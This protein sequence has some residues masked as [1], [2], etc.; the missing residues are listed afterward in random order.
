[1][2]NDFDMFLAPI[3]MLI[4]AGLGIAMVISLARSGEWVLAVLVGI[5]VGFGVVLVY[6]TAQLL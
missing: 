5:T 2:E 6:R 3:A 1:M 4:I